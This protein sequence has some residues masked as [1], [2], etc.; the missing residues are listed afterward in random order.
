MNLTQNSVDTS[1]AGAQSTSQKSR[2]GFRIKFKGNAP[3][4]N[5]NQTQDG[6]LMDSSRTPID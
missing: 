6:I 2:K 1:D 4:N 5:L 3:N